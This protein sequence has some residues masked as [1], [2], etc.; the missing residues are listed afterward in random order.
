M[1]N[2]VMLHRENFHDWGGPEWVYDDDRLNLGGC[3][4]QKLLEFLAFMVH[5]R[6]RPDQQDVDRLVD[7]V[8]SV[9]G[10]DGFSLVA[11]EEVSGKRIFAGVATVAEHGGYIEEAA[12]IADEMS[13]SHVRRQVDRMKNSVAADPALAIGSAKE[14]LES[15]AKG[16]LRDQGITLTGTEPMP[17]LIKLARDQLNL[18]ITKDTDLSLKKVLSGLSTITQGLAELRGKLGTGHGEHPD[19]KLPPVEIARLAVGM[20]TTLGVFLYQMRP[21]PQP[22]TAPTVTPSS[23]SAAVMHDDDLPF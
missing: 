2:D 19:V 1:L 18:S 6:V 21:N 11:I 8:N 22:T 5:P 7:I 9:I 16:I 4:D 13:S 14:F 17:T 3:P 10:R 23:I 12:R 15:I 20:A